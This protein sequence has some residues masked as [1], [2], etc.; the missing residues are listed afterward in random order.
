M[1]GMGLAQLGTLEARG[2]PVLP[3]RADN[4]NEVSAEH[5]E[6]DLQCASSGTA[7]FTPKILKPR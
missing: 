6:Y 4:R 1:L 7:A 3:D 2:M 5:G